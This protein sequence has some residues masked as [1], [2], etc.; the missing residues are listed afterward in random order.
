MW[1]QSCPLH[2]RHIAMTSPRVS[3]IIATY[4][5]SSVLRYAIASV[6]YQSIGDF[7]L[8]V[9]GDGCT[10]DSEEVVAGIKDPRVRWINLPANSGHQ[11]GPNSRGLQEARGEFVAY[12]GHDDLWLKH[13]LECT[14]GKLEE[15]GAAFAHSLLI[16]ILSADDESGM[17]VFPKP[18]YGN[19]G[20]PSCTVHR[21]S[22]AEKI[23][24]WND[25]RDLVIPPEADFFNRA[26][27]A[28]FTAVFV[29]RLTAIKF[30]GAI[31]KNVYRDKPSHEQAHWFRRMSEP[32]FEAEH[33][34]HM[35]KALSTEVASEMPIRKLVR[36]F[37]LEFAA[38]VRG[39]LSRLSLYEGKEI[40]GIK[41]FK[42]L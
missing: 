9:V 21:R 15:T 5:R 20:P 40:E 8:L 22:V 13:H 30:P 42:G 28:G 35:I 19:G 26:R 25:Y 36:T 32:D 31:R 1:R 3:V 17:P 37:A 4:N 18:Q 29:P 10:D 2:A 38:R 39:R 6:L 7:E 24:G 12:L 27:A 33:L 34:V 14:I 16:R 11:S 41:R 23:G